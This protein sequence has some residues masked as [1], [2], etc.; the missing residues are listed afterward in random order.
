[1]GLLVQWPGLVRGHLLQAARLLLLLLLNKP[2]ELEWR[3]VL[4]AHPVVL[5]LHSLLL[6]LLLLLL[7]LVVV[8]RSRLVSVL[9][10]HQ[11]C[12]QPRAPS[13][14]LGSGPGPG[15]TLD[16]H[17]RSALLDRRW[18]WLQPAVAA[19]VGRV[20]WKVLPQ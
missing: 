13:W 16:E 5:R 8:A 19:A 9:L 11:G 18:P 4:V 17:L 10:V 3:A 2:G 12:C 6:L 15:L 1:V 14:Q 7:V 20:A